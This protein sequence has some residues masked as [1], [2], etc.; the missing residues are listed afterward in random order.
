MSWA[1]LDDQMP[2]DDKITGL[3][4][5]AFRAYV[6]AICFSARMLTDGVVP[7]RKLNEFAGRRARAVVAELTPLLLHEP[8]DHCDSKHCSHLGSLTKGNYLIHNY[9]KYNPTR[10]KELKRRADVNETKRRAGRA[11]A[12]A[13]WQKE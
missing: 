10:E 3:S 8:G 5:A 13:R 1:K 2:D 6:T 9:L 12:A 7:V 4:D 11:G